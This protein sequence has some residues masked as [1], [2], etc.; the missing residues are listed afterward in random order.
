MEVSFTNENFL[1]KCKFPLKKENSCP[2]FF[3]R[4]FPTSG[5][6]GLLVQN[7]SYAKES[8]FGVAYA[9]TPPSI[10]LITLGTSYKRNR[11]TLVLL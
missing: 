5:S 3:L 11:V 7:N 10:K 1:Y 6:Q 2:L 8:C 9:G 4:A